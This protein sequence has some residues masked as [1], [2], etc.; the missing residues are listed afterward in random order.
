MK[1]VNIAIKAATITVFASLTV[2]GCKMNVDLNPTAGGKPYELIVSVEDPVWN[3]E[4]KDTLEA[5]FAAPVEM[6]NQYEPLFDV[7]RVQNKS[8]NDLIIRHRNILIINVD[9][10][11]REPI[12][13]AQ[14]DPYSSPQLMVTLSAPD[15]KSMAAYL[16]RSKTE[17]QQIFDIQERNRTVSYNEKYGNA[18]L[19]KQIES[20]FGVKMNIPNSFMMKNH[21]GHNFMWF[22][23]E[24]PVASQAVV[25]YSYPFTG[26]D[27]FD[28]ENLIRRRNEFVAAIPG[29][30]YPEVDS[31]MITNQ[32]PE[33][34][35]V[36]RYLRID[37]HPWAEMRGFWDVY[38]DHMGGPFV[39]YSTLLPDRAEVLTIEGYLY[40]PKNPKRNY[41]R[42]LE[43]LVY[44][45]EFPEEA[46]DKTTGETAGGTAATVEN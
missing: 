3:S 1:S 43:H 24:F 19:E 6:I 5:I 14:I 20:M 37:D 2:A 42:Q 4:V 31:Y 22:G 40:S 8:M 17:L 44:T 34:M 16:S 13:S 35:P 46:T 39:S 18:V 9:K 41:L 10:S 11:V 26:K 27:N 15:I 29:P 23:E 25:I 30:R 45:V 7:R 12:T 32:L 21:N 28:L 36:V 38:N 33:A